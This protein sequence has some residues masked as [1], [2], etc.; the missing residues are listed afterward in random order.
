MRAIIL[1]VSKNFFMLSLSTLRFPV[2]RLPTLF[3]PTHSDR[4]IVVESAQK[5]VGE[6]KVGSLN[7]VNRDVGSDD[8]KQVVDT[9]EIITRVKPDLL[10]RLKSVAA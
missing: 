9:H 8:I 10:S 6:N 5:C 4:V 3:S 7:T 1:R 2:F